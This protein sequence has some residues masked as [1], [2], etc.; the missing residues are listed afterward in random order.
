MILI[1]SWLPVFRVLKSR[2]EELLASF[3]W[4]LASR[5][6]FEQLAALTSSYRQRNQHNSF[7]QF[8]S[9]T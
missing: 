7:S 5:A 9:C 3:E 2:P 6:E 8:T 1:K 4:E